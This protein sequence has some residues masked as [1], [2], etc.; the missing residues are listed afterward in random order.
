MTLIIRMKKYTKLQISIIKK[1]LEATKLFVTKK[2]LE[3]FIQASYDKITI[4]WNCYFFF[5]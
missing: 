2:A 3:V 1:L 5:Y 4:F